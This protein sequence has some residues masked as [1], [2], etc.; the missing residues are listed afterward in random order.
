[1]SIAAKGHAYDAA[2]RIDSKV[3]NLWR[4]DG[5]EGDGYK[6]VVSLAV[7]GFN[8]SKPRVTVRRLKV[9]QFWDLAKA[10]I[11]EMQLPN[12]IV[13]FDEGGR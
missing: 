3:R 6:E 13:Q 8:E 12:V 2:I 7:G 10:G 4:I 1:M 11:L 9:S 5:R